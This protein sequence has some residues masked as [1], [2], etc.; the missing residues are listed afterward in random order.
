MHSTPATNG[1]S[2]V[3]IVKASASWCCAWGQWWPPCVVF[4]GSGFKIGA[5]KKKI[6]GG[7]TRAHAHDTCVGIPSLLGF[8]SRA[9][10]SLIQAS[11]VRKC[12]RSAYVHRRRCARLGAECWSLRLN[13]SNAGP[14]VALH[15]RACVPVTCC[16]FRSFSEADW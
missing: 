9:T 2:S 3:S 7:L 6:L 11:I 8:S 15:W 16:V 10:G 5:A 13:I 1:P 12:A 4:V 14:A